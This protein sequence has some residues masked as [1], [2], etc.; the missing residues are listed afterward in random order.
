MKKIFI[1]TETTGLEPKKNGIIALSFM[2]ESEDGKI[3]D[4]GLL[5]MNAFAYSKTYSPAA[6]KINGFTVEQIKAFPSPKEAL[7]TF[8]KALCKHSNDEK[9]TIVAYNAKFDKDMLHALYESVYPGRY[10]KILSHKVIDT[11][12]IVLFFSDIGLIKTKKHNLETVAKC[13]DFVHVPHNC[14]SDNKVQR[15]IYRSL[16]DMTID[17]VNHT[18]HLHDILEDKR[19]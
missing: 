16:Y 6:L 5:H 18:V 15:A 3:L 12:Q 1:D 8:D 13:F 14:A 2:I 11:M 9:Y 10:W 17:M 19:S 7:D 4:E